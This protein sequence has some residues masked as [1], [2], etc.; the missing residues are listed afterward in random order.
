MSGPE[1]IVLPSRKLAEGVVEKLKSCKENDRI[2][3]TQN[4]RVGSREWQT[5]AEGKFRGISYL[6]TGITTE[7]V[8]E[9]DI[10]VPTVHFVK[11]NGELTS[12]TLDNQSSIEKLS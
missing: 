8:P 11:D 1:K 9:D 6:A 10:I 4:V 2:K 3:V 7:R 12:I 5:T